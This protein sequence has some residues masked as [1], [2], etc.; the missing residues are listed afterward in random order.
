VLEPRGLQADLETAQGK[1]PGGVP[2]RASP[3]SGIARWITKPLVSSSGGSKPR[4]VQPGIVEALS[5]Q[6]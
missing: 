5:V 1:N 2:E 3:G 6:A 4:S